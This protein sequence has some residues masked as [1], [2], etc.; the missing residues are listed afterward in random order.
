MFRR[1][2]TRW[3]RRFRAGA[4]DFVG[5]QH[6]GEQWSRMKHQGLLF[7]FIDGHAAEIARHQVGGKLHAR[8]LQAKAACQRMGEG[9]FTD[10]RD[11]VY[12]QVASGQQAG[13]AVPDLRGFADDHRVKLIQKTF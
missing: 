11:I 1:D 7:A 2:I 6:L 9:G 12:E 13:Y 8:K 5:Q 10:T 4:I 3:P